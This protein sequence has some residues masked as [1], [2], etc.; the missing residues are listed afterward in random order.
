MTELNN[1]P[2]SD[3][4][5]QEQYPIEPRYHPVNLLARK[6]YD[7]LA[8]AKLAMFLLTAILA[9]C[10]VGVTLYKGYVTSKIIF[11]SLWFNGLLVLLVTNVA[12]CFFGRIWGRRVTVISFGM[13]LF[14]L[15]FVLVFLG[16]VYN[17]LFYFRGSTRLTESGELISGDSHNYEAIDKGRFFSFSQLKGKISLVRLHPDYK[18]EGEN[19]R[20]AYEVE[21]G[22]EESRKQGLIYT[23]NKLTYRG[24][25]YFNDKEGYSLLVVLSDSKG[26]DLFGGYVPLQSIKQKNGDYQYV[27]GFKEK[28]TVEK[29]VIPFPFSPEKPQFALQVGYLPS[30]LKERGG[31]ATFQITALDDKGMPRNTAPIAEGKAAIGTVFNAGEYRLSAR[32]VRYWVS[33]NVR[34][35]PGKPIVLASLWIGFAGIAITTFGRMMKSTKRA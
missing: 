16:I 3:T 34:F 2:E 29:S 1:L 11:D 30:K 15:S 4:Q 22:E 20:V 18:V 9:S 5:D 8:S 24:V 35:E 26:Q 32:E 10:I 21:V 25:D 14:H 17:S 19:K 12:C 7:F 27:T 13:I 33:M 31:D 28:E 6:I 23:T